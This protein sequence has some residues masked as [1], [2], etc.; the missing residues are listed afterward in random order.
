MGRHEEL[1][2]AAAGVGICELLQPGERLVAHRGAA[3]FDR[4][5]PRRQRKPVGHLYLTS[6]RLLFVGSPMTSIPLESIED[7]ILL[8]DRI[9][10]MLRGGVGILIDVDRPHLLR[11]QIAGARASQREG[12]NDRWDAQRSPR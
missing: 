7:A 6:A 2:S 8:G 11:E 12:R 9:Q 4:R 5:Q 10:L 3:T 1:E